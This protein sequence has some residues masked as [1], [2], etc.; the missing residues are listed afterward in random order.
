MVMVVTASLVLMVVVLV[1]VVAWEG[2]WSGISQL[3]L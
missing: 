2:L 3:F 1:V